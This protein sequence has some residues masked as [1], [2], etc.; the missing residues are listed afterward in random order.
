KPERRSN[1]T[2]P[3][4]NEGVSSSIRQRGQFLDS[5]DTWMMTRF[6]SNDYS[7]ARISIGIGFDHN[8]NLGPSAG[9]LA[10]GGGG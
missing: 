4:T 8:G 2:K 10:P 3:Q 1:P 6:W 9:F 7:A 5:L